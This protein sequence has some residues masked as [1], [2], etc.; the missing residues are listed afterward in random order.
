MLRYEK[1]CCSKK[2]PAIWTPELRQSNLIIQYWN[3]SIKAKRKNIN[4]KSRL[5]R[6]TGKMW[7]RTKQQIL[8]NTKSLTQA[9][10]EALINHE[11]LLAKNTELRREYLLQKIKDLNDRDMKSKITLTQLIESKHGMIF[12]I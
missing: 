12:P 9:L 8:N 3:V 10:N 11:K 1:K 2:D 6:I 7:D 5:K 4:I